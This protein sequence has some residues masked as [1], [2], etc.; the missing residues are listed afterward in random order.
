MN[1]CRVETIEVS[2]QEGKW[3]D[4]VRE[5]CESISKEANHP[6]IIGSA[7]LAADCLNS[8]LSH[9]VVKLDC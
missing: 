5:M 4:R 1:I 7:Q 8:L 2:F 9:V 3:F 6:E